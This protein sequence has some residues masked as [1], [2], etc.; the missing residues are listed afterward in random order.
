[1]DAVVLAST[2]TSSAASTSGVGV[3]TNIDFAVI[4]EGNAPISSV[5]AQWQSLDATP[6]GAQPSVQTLGQLPPDSPTTVRL[7]LVRSCGSTSAAPVPALL[8]TW[9]RD[10]A[11]QR[12][13]VAPFGLDRIWAGLEGYCVT[14]QAA[15]VPPDISVVKVTP[16]RADTTQLELGFRNRGD[17][18]IPI[19]AL[20]ISGAFA[21]VVAQ[22]RFIVA[23][24]NTSTVVT[25]T[26]KVE[27]CQSAIERSYTAGLSYSALSGPATVNPIVMTDELS[28]TLGELIY[29]ACGHA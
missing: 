13:V 21:R 26:V 4:N 23:R 17:D 12:L 8:L 10:G 25:I 19:A 14:P 9:S 15:F 5:V 18:D 11:P 7:P 16:V 20:D 29:R 3:T 24:A 1:V 28:R 6:A 2:V 22:P 27:N